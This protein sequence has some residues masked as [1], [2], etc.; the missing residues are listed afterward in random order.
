MSVRC[1][2]EGGGTVL[3]SAHRRELVSQGF[4]A[5]HAQIG[6]ASMGV[7]APGYPFEPSARVQVSSTQ[8]LIRRGKPDITPSVIVLDEFHHYAAE[9]FKVLTEWWPEARILGPTAT[10]QRGDGKPLGDIAE[11][12]VVAAQYSQLVE[13]G[14][15]CD[16]VVYQPPKVVEGRAVAQ[17]PVGAWQRYSRGMPGFAFCPTIKEAR[18]LADSFNATGIVAA[19]IDAN[20][21]KPERSRILECFSSGEIRVV[22]NVDTMT[23]GVDVP[24]SGCVMLM[25]KF[26]ASGAYM[27]A[28]GRGLR[29]HSSKEYC[30][31]ID[32]TGASLFHG[33]P[34]VDRDYSLDGDGMR[35]SAGAEDPQRACQRCG[36]TYS[37]SLDNC[38]AC[39]QLKPLKAKRPLRFHDIELEEVWAG[40]LTKEDAKLREYKRLRDHQKA[41]GLSLFF[42][43]KTYKETFGHSPKLFDIGPEEKRLV[44]HQLQESCKKTGR[45]PSAAAAQFSKLFGHWPSAKSF[46]IQQNRS[47][48]F[49]QGR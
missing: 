36:Y 49:P 12:L 27:Q 15:L 7:I 48:G 30:V 24:A 28:C 20:T 45:S 25:R 35:K 41:R 38:P 1:A 47:G 14:Y 8:L 32:L 23:E 22:T 46:G 10:P 16:A 11:R 40:E 9:E 43:I 26:Q 39:G 33:H 18:A 13:D 19:C 29:P 31:I 34:I 6:G 44:L 37:C 2:L 42:V 5:L 21:K 3:W 17:D 4:A